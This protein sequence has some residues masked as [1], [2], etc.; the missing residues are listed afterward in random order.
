MTRL[1]SR[2][3]LSITVLC[4]PFR[5]CVCVGESILY[6]WFIYE[7]IFMIICWF[8]NIQAQKHFTVTSVSTQHRSQLLITVYNT[9]RTNGTSCVRKITRQYFMLLVWF[10]FNYY[11]L[12]YSKQKHHVNVCH[13]CHLFISVFIRH[14]FTETKSLFSQ[15]KIWKCV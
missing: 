14:R 5:T 15:N 8:V 2:W 11:F 12:N 6:I 3:R 9:V 13:K 4:A 7:S 1:S 10:I